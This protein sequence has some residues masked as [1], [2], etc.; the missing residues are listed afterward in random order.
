MWLFV[1]NFDRN[2][3]NAV[4]K[5]FHNHVVLFRLQLVNVR[6]ELV[7]HAAEADL[8]IKVVKSRAKK[9]FIQVDFISV[10]IELILRLVFDDFLRVSQLRVIS[11]EWVN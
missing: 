4:Q 10:I 9:L 11:C 5:L 6:P 2:A 7:S 8:T 1:Q 3:L